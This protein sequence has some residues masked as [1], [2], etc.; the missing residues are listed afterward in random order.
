MTSSPT[1]KPARL[2]AEYRERHDGHIWMA[3]VVVLIDGE[4]SLASFGSGGYIGLAPADLASQEA[5]VEPTNDPQ[6]VLLYRCDCGETGCGAVVARCYRHGNEV[7]W[8][9]FDFGNPPP[10][11]L[12]AAR[13]AEDAMTFSAEEYELFVLRL[14]ELHLRHPND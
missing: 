6:E 14:R 4:E 13:K 3:G 9:R 2:A 12:S 8:D 11:D 5:V 7:V 1:T 10:V